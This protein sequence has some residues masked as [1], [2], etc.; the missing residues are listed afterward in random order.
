[1]DNTKDILYRAA[2]KNNGWLKPSYDKRTIKIGNKVN[3]NGEVL[4][5]D[6]TKKFLINIM[7][8]LDINEYDI[9]TIDNEFEYS[10]QLYI[11]EKSF[12]ELK[13]KI[14]KKENFVI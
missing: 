9:E 2:I 4:K 5:N 10:Y 8:K 1:M 13:E 7:K 14:D 12:Q 11:N 3:C 6:N